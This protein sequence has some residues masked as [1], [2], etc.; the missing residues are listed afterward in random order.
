MSQRDSLLAG[1]KEAKRLH[2]ILGVERNIAK[3]GG[4]VDVFGAALHQDTTLMFQSLTGILG[5]YLN[6]EGTPGI[7][8][9]TQRRLAVQRFTGAHELGHFVMG[10]ATSVD[11]DDI[12]GCLGANLPTPEIEANAFAAEF[13]SPRWLL[14]YHARQQGWDRSSM[15]DPVCVYQLSLRIGMSYDATCRSLFLQKLITQGVMQ[16]LLAIQPKQIKRSILPLPYEPKN[17]YGD[18]WLLGE[19]DQ[20]TDL[21]GHPDDHFVVRLPEKS[22]AGYLWS[23]EA[24]R[25]EGFNVLHEAH[26]ATPGESLIGSDALYEVTTGPAPIALGK[27]QLTQARP[28]QPT[29]PLTIVTVNYD[30]RGK[31]S[32]MSRAERRQFLA[33]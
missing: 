13:L 29:P 21:E 4:R 3:T 14:A 10:H 19:H 8:I 5:A 7:I 24:L 17:W 18:V 33:A 26:N 1:A 15:S 32:G 30:V 11:K 6:E 12:L 2:E 31:E 20:G 28:W 22:G 16:T 25:A 27:F 9:T 23:V